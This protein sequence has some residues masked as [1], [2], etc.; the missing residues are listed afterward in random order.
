[1][2]NHDTFRPSQ[3]FRSN[4]P[5]YHV[6]GIRSIWRRWP[7]LSLLAGCSSLLRCQ[8]FCR[9][10]FGKKKWAFALEDYYEC[11]HHKK[12]HARAVAMQ[13][14]FVRQGATNN[15]DAPPASQI[16]NLGLLNK[17]E[18]SKKVIGGS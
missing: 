7:L 13:T 9:G 17:E 6:V 3:S 14:A 8:Y 2:G 1:M 16:R 15:P 5:K 10:R 12:E 4:P 11:L 18:D